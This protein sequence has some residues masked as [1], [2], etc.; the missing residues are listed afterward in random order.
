M[1]SQFLLEGEITWENMEASFSGAT[2]YI[3]LEET[4]RADF[5]S[6]II[7]EQIIQN[8]SLHTGGKNKLKISLHGEIPDKKATYIVSVHIDTDG[9]GQVSPGDYITVESYPVL[10]FGHPNQ[11]AICVRQIK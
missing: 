8:V 3:R 11:V 7:A 6:R 4:S 1:S 5:A 2:A 9:D 10:T